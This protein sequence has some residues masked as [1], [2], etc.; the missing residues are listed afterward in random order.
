MDNL[1]HKEQLKELISSR[2]LQK[3][4]FELASE[5]KSQIFFN[6]KAISLESQGLN[7]IAHTFWDEFESWELRPTIFAGVSLGADPLVSAL[8]L[9][10][11]KRGVPSSQA[12]MIRKTVKDH[13]ATKGRA[14]EGINPDLL[15]K[16]DQLWL[17]E[18]VIT[19]GKSSFL[20]AERLRA[21]GYPL[22]G[23][24]TIVDREAGGVS[25]L[26]QKLG[27]KVKSL[28]KMSEFKEA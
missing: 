12:L 19:S 13:G 23:I 14:V 15:Q 7:C 18:D 24:F 17:F 5:A 26:R 16:N 22:A 4:D 8:I 27:V 11:L 10:A 6:M 28:F 25:F 1:N 3:G 21:E 20:G 2:A 9:E